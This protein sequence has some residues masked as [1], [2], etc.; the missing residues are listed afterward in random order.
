M[1]FY[2]LAT[3]VAGVAAQDEEE[4]A[5]TFGGGECASTADSV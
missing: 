1:K 4:A 2:T 3:L 5:C